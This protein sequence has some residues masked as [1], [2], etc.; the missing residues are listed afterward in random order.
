[1]AIAQGLVSRGISVVVIATVEDSAFHE[2]TQS[3]HGVEIHRLAMPTRILLPFLVG[4]RNVVRTIGSRLTVHRSE[5]SEAESQLHAPAA[6]GSASAGRKLAGQLVPWIEVLDRYKKWSLRAYYLARH[7]AKYRNFDVVIASGPPFSSAVAAVAIGRYLRVP[8]V[9]DY[10]DPVASLQ[11][12]GSI[13]ERFGRLVCRVVQKFLVRH[14]DQNTATSPGIANL[15]GAFLPAGARPIKIVRNGFDGTPQDRKSNSGHRMNIVF[16]GALYLNRSP[17]IFLA[18]LKEL[19]EDHDVDATRVTVSFFGAVDSP[20]WL[21]LASIA[22]SPP[23]KGVVSVFPLVSGAELQP[24]LVSATAV[25]NLAQGQPI[26]IPAKTFEQLGLGCEV[27]AVCERDSD[28]GRLLSS[29]PGVHVIGVDD[30]IAMGNTLR[31]IYVRHVVQGIVNPPSLDDIREFSR[32]S[33]LNGFVE[34][35]TTL[36]DG[37]LRQA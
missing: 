19:L 13:G 5:P 21:E 18:A 3:C 12:G 25:L 32:A 30:S 22:R 7:L 24:H 31:D 16:A 20:E 9:V 36:L 10:R 1:V 26:Q 17:G 15:L 14:A 28:T 23:Y 8:I 35:V 34:S 33:Q 11:V 37:R 2:E 29:V 6:A 4:A 27:I